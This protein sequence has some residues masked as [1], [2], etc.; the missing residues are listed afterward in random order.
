M[1]GKEQKLFLKRVKEAWSTDFPFLKPVE[2]DEVPKQ[3]KGCNFRCEDYFSTRGVCY[4][5]TFHFSQRR[6]GEFSVSIAVSPSRDKSVLN[7]PEIYIPAPKNVGSYSMA[8]FL[9][10]QSFRW[11]LTDVDA[12]TNGTLLSLGMASLPT[13]DYV[14]ANVWKP[15]SYALPFEQ[16]A[17]EAIRD[18]SNKLRQFIFPKLEIAA[19]TEASTANPCS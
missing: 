8:V 12:K 16:I 10:R 1:M 7:S 9:N 3:P 18:L 5:V 19:G 11:D 4:F 6:Q 17:D 15:S 14:S 13:A 2:L